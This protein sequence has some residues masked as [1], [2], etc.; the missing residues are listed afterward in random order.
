[1]TLVEGISCQNKLWDPAPSRAAA[2]EQAK[3]F[4][5]KAGATGITNLQFGSNEGTS[6]RTN[7]WELI[8]VSAEAIQLL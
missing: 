6:T 7:C 2:I 4:A 5:L 1:M 3:Y 8:R